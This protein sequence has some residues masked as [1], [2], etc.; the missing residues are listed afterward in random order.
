MTIIKKK[1]KLESVDEKVEK[2]ESLYIAGM[3]VKY[4]MV[5]PL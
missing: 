3:Y 5:Q 4:K 2:L 1:N